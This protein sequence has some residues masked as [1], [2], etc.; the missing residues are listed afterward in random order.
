MKK[1]LTTCVAGAIALIS[2]GQ[3]F[4]EVTTPGLVPLNWSLAATAD[5]NSDGNMDV[6][7]CG[8][9][10]ID[11]VQSPARHTYIHL[12]NGDGTFELLEQNEGLLGFSRYVHIEVADFN[13]D[14]HLDI[15]Y[16]GNSGDQG[17][18][19]IYLYLNDGTGQFTQA[20]GFPQD[21]FY[22]Y[23][24]AIE[25]LD[26][27][28]DGNMDIMVSMWGGPDGAYNSVLVRNNGDETFDFDSSLEN[29]TDGYVDSAL[30]VGDFDNDGDADALVTG[31][32][33]MN[34]DADALWQNNDGMF[35]QIDGVGFSNPDP[36]GGQHKFSSL[37]DVDGDGN[38]DIALKS[39]MP[40]GED[41]LKTLI[42]FGGG[43]GTFTVEILEYMAATW[44]WGPNAFG[45]LTQDG[46]IDIYM[47]RPLKLM[48]GNG[49]G[50]FNDAGNSGVMNHFWGLYAV[51]F[52]GDNALD[53]LALGAVDVNEGGAAVYLNDNSVANEAPGKP[54]NLAMTK[55]GTDLILSWD[56]ANDDHTTQA[57]LS[58]NIYVKESWSYLY[59]C[60]NRCIFQCFAK[61]GSNFC[62]ITGC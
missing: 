17:H 59:C 35:T 12:G 42:G 34:T 4:N 53:V 27:N 49:D 58:Y 44:D 13:N 40:W 56:A 31:Y 11:G 57:S 62:C 47:T 5:F 6:I 36:T 46:N 20:S 52:N 18:T 43:D 29:A 2:Y 9:H 10:W 41:K 23:N 7:S 45:D 22:D 3:S 8:H 51:D 61:S 38:L 32:R 14:G 33:N 54:T 37:G 26:Y 28:N 19:G 60:C 24:G 15:V 30:E 16:G 48:A 1:L 50:S 39:E 21:F 55:D 25:A